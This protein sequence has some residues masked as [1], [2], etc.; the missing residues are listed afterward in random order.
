MDIKHISFFSR[1]LQK[2]MNIKIYGHDGRP[3]IMF[4]CQDS[5]CNNYED[6]GM[7]DTIADYVDGGALQLFCVDT[8]DIDSWSN[9]AGDKGW[10][11]W[12]QEQYFNYII[13][14]VLPVIYDHNHSGKQP[15]TFGC[16]LGATHAAITFLRRPDLFS[17]MLALSG[18]YDARYFFDGWMDENLWKNSPIDILD[19]IHPGHWYVD[20]YNQKKIIFC[21][22]Q[23]AW[24]DEG[25]RTTA[26]LKDMFASKGIGAWCDFWGYDVNHDWPWWKIQIRYFL[27]HLV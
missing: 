27:P 5:M 16:S 10:R 23:G 20:V 17:G 26:I 2:E 15:I 25:R 12:R 24:E 1:H 18:V 7:V 13:D 9:V 11:S 14:E 6:F 21:I 3:V 22:G 19:S 4:P 8:V